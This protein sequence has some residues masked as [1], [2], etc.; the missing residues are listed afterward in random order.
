LNKKKQKKKQKQKNNYRRNHLKLIPISPS[1]MLFELNH[2]QRTH[3]QTLF[4]KTN[5]ETITRNLEE[6]KEKYARYNEDE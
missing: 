1:K 2:C 6:L 3:I 4:K 5:F